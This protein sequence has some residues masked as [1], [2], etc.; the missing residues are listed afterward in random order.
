MRRKQE[1]DAVNNVITPVHQC[2]LELIQATIGNVLIML[3]L[4][5]LI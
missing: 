5:Y 1:K 4:A 2:E 3:F